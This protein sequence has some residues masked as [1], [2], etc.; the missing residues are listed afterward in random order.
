VIVLQRVQ[1]I[2][3]SDRLGRRHDRRVSNILLI[4]AGLSLIPLVGFDATGL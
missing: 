3:Q 1:S 2:S 4:L